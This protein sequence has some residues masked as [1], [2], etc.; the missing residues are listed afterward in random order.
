MNSYE[1]VAELLHAQTSAFDAF[2]SR[3]N[4]AVSKLQRDLDNEKRHVDELE[5]RF[6]R[7]AMFA[8]TATTTTR[9]SESPD[10]LAVLTK[11][12]RA[13]I[14][15]DQTGAD[16]AIAE[17]KT[18]AI[19]VDPGGGYFVSPQLSSSLL[20]VAAE[21][22]PMSRYARTV[23]MA[24]GDAHE[25]II[26]R[27]RAAAVWA[28]EAQARPNTATPEIGK[29]R[30]ELHELYAS[31]PV[32]QRLIDDSS[33]DV[34]GW[35]ANKLGEAFG[36]TEGHAFL[37]GTGVGQPR[38]VLTY[39]VDATDDATRAWGTI[40][41]LKTGANGGFLTTA[42][43]P[44]CLIN[45]VAAMRAQYRNGAMW[46]MSRATEGL[47]MRLKDQQGRF[48]W[49]QSL[50]SGQPNTLAGFPVVI[51][52]EMPNPQTGSHSIMLVNPTK[53]YCI[54]R[55]PGIRLLNDPYTAKPHVILYGTTRVG[56]SMQNSEAVKLLAFEA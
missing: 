55:R 53:A 20:S 6:N 35:L 41:V 25:E 37:H 46:W 3:H 23:P 10:Q 39:P 19:G 48:L 49:Q 14:A 26:D 56:G 9:S 22:S 12:V 38:G 28:G 40:Q 5:K 43:A 11:G 13:W 29:M 36:I 54:V 32:T 24:T 27:G 33:F 1:E 4:E 34:L 45:T 18:M 51:D 50:V 52:E 16:R 8:G 42:S 44:D 21:I 30:I 2:K 47:V 17:Y 31:P 15:G 7:T